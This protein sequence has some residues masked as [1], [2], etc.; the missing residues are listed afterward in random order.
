M[1]AA[2]MRLSSLVLHTPGL[3]TQQKKSPAQLPIVFSRRV[4]TCAS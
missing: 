4:K 3:R 1:A 2:M